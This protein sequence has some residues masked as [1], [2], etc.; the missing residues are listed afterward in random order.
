M[1]VS[2]RVNTV[3]SALSLT[4]SLAITS[5]AASEN[6]STASLIQDV[7]QRQTAFSQ[8]DKQQKQINKAL[9]NSTPNWQQL[10]VQSAEL[11]AHSASLQTLFVPGS[12]SGSKAK[13]KVWDDNMK[14]KAALTKMDNS[15]I[16]MDGA[17]KQQDKYAAKDALK[18]ANK[19]CRNCHRQYRSR[20]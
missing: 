4:L 18:E 12:Q 9:G 15:F 3:I 5:V 6:L 11:T 1:S 13:D 10:E 7:E 8:I 14:F 20:W 2:K 17:I 19:T 16:K